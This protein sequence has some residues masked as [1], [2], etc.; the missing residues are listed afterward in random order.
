MPDGRG[1]QNEGGY[2]AD[3]RVTTL[4]EDELVDVIANGR[5]PKGMP[6]WKG[7]IDDEKIRQLATFIKEDLKLKK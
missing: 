4:T 1:G 2:G 3:L 6:A 5:M 7:M